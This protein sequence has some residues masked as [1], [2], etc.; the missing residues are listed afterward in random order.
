MH[1][2][3]PS[4]REAPPNLPDVRSSPQPLALFRD[5]SASDL[6]VLRASVNAF[7]DMAALCTRTLETFGGSS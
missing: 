2:T 3:A 6:R 1:A 4:P 5:F 7:M